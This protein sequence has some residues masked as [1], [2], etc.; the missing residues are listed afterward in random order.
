MLPGADFI[1][2]EEARRRV[3]YAVLAGLNAEGFVPDDSEHMGLLYVRPCQLMTGCGIDV[4]AF[5]ATNNAPPQTWDAALKALMGSRRLL[6]RPGAAPDGHPLRD[7]EQPERNGGQG[8]QSGP[9]GAA[10]KRRRVVVLWIDD[11]AVAP[12]WL[13][14]L[15]ILLAEVVPDKARCGCAS[16]GPSSR[17]TWSAR[18]SMI[19]RLSAR[20]W[21]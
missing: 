13:S 6:R 16:S 9:Q 19:C 11:T 3:R 12:R 4:G 14:A 17:T 20:R 7:A 21:S 18:L 15:T 2:V 10:R 5:L 1:G 8:R